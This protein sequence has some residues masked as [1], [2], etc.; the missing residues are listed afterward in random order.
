MTNNQRIITIMKE[1]NSNFNSENFKNAL[2]FLDSN[3]FKM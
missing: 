3:C 1:D 2:K